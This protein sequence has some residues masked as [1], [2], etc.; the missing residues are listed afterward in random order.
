MAESLHSRRIRI[1]AYF[2]IGIGLAAFAFYF[3]LPILL[4]SMGI[5]IL[6]TKTYFVVAHFHWLT[7]LSVVIG[8]AAAITL[9]RTLYARF[10]GS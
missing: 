3:T 4:G 8:I 1:L 5:D 6:L 9:A 10:I 2:A 7:L